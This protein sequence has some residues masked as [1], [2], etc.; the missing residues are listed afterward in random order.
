M[1]VCRDIKRIAEASDKCTGGPYLTQ[2]RPVN[3]RTLPLRGR[4]D[5]SILIAKSV[6]YRYKVLAFHGSGAVFEEGGGDMK[7]IDVSW[8]GCIKGCVY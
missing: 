8:G 5:F 2:S 7:A 3:I 1:D 6:E 4:I